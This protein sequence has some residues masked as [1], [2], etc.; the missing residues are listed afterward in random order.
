MVIVEIQKTYD[1]NTG[2]I[3]EQSIENNRRF[4]YV[5]RNNINASRLWAID[6]NGTVYL[7]NPLTMEVL[8]TANISYLNII[9]VNV[10]SNEH[11]EVW[12]TYEGVHSRHEFVLSADKNSFIVYASYFTSTVDIVLYAT[13]D[14]Y[15]DE[16]YVYGR[17]PDGYYIA[18]YNYG[19]SQLIIKKRITEYT[20]EIERGEPLII[21]GNNRVFLITFRRGTREIFTSVYIRPSLTLI[22]WFKYLSSEVASDRLPDVVVNAMIDRSEGIIAYSV[23]GRIASALGRLYTWV[24]RNVDTGLGYRTEGDMGVSR[25]TYCY[26]T[27][28]GRYACFTATNGIGV[29]NTATMGYYGVG[30]GGSISTFITNDE[31]L[32]IVICIDR[33]EYR[34]LSDLALLNQNTGLSNSYL[35]ANF[36]IEI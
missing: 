20:Q 23:Q 35:I 17:D 3:T 16:F 28:D 34:R 19:M 33:V 31:K 14:F 13:G 4:I 30:I 25:K 26:L 15:A 11:L 24:V 22:T 32:A 12:G 21:Y 8:Q 18:R 29:V 1:I 27:A 6:N 9:K 5:V 2:Q 10:L 36:G 7:Y